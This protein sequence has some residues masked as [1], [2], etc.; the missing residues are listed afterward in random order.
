MNTNFLDS[1]TN[2]LKKRTFELL[3]LILILASLV[4]AV[5]FSTYSPEDPSFVFGD[6][7]YE[8]QNLM[9]FYGSGVA[10]FLLQSFG[11][12]S[13]LLLINFLFWGLDLIFKKEIKR[14]TLKLF[15]VVSYLTI[16]TVFIYVTF[17]NS[18]WLI[19]NGNSGFVGELVYTFLKAWMPWIDHSYSV[20][21]MLILTLV[22]FSFS[23][24]ISYKTLFS[25]L[26]N[27][28]KRE[29]IESTLVSNVNYLKENEKSD[30]IDKSQQSFLF[31]T[32]VTT[33][34]ESNLQKSKFKLPDISYLEK[35]LG[36]LESAN[37][38]KNRPEA[39][40][41]EKI[42][43]DFGIDGKI[44]NLIMVRL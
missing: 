30:I 23:A 20:Y 44:K 14:I 8:I 12:A 29:S 18:F 15:L 37:I 31:D 28:F 25:K 3:G 16:G 19:D 41:M 11:L 17:D 26:I 5:S 7:N 9:G 33:K 34:T 1:L 2:F 39:E 27:I 36:R 6:K 43:L 42:L 24:D 35:K 4:L 10:D 32:N 38:T 40:F 21:G 13:F 22:L